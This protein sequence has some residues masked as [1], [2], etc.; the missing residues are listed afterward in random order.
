MVSLDQVPQP[1]PHMGLIHDTS[2]VS[3]GNWPYFWIATFNRALDDY[4]SR[5]CWSKRKRGSKTRHRVAGV[6]F[7]HCI[8]PRSDGPSHG[9]PSAQQPTES[10]FGVGPCWWSRLLKI[11]PFPFECGFAPGHLHRNHQHHRIIFN[12]VGVAVNRRIGEI[13]A[14]PYRAHLPSY[15]VL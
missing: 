7:A 15:F 12:E 8:G 2:W 6:R 11:P 10:R 3:W 5:G 9:P 14:S 1:A 4:V 13:C